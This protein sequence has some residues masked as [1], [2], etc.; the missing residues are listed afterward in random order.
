MVLRGLT[1]VGRDTLAHEIAQNHLANVVSVFEKTG[2]VHENYAPESTAP[3]VPSKPEFVG[4]TGLPPIAVL[5]EY[6]FGLRADAAARRLV[7][8]VRLTEAH[9]VRRYPF[10]GDAWLDLSCASR[11]A[12]TDPPRIEATATGPVDIEV[13]WAGGTRLLKIGR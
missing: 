6:V 4:W 8:D 9:G 7:W 5:L 3:G 11:R 13:R 1:A 10:G 2:T 12:A